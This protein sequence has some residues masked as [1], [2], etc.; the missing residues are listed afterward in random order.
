MRYEELG[1]K[2]DEHLKEIGH[3][4]NFM[5]RIK[6]FNNNSTIKTFEEIFGEENAE[7]LRTTHLN[8]NQDFGRFLTYLTSSQQ[9]DLFIY[10]SNNYSG[11]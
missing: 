5:K 6:K 9:D 3:F 7:R 1:L 10:V 8:L 11:S 4:M 2:S